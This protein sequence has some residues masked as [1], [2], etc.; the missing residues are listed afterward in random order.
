M[1]SSSDNL[2]QLL[3]AWSKGDENALEKLTPMIYR[4]LHRLARSYMV[5]VRQL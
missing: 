5:C 1:T 3:L 2:T 4:E